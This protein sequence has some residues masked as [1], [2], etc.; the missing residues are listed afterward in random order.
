MLGSDFF[1]GEFRRTGGAQEEK[2]PKKPRK[3]LYRGI[4][5][6]PWGKWAAEI[7]DP[8]KGVRV[9][10]GTYNTAEEAARA[11]DREAR[12]IRGKKAKVNFPN[13]DDAFSTIP[14]HHAHHPQV[15]NYPPLYQANWNDSRAPAKA[16]DL[17][18][19]YDLNQTGQFPPNGFAPIHAVHAEPMVISSEEI[20]GSG[21]EDTHASS[22]VELGAN[23]GAQVKVKEEGGR[24]GE[25]EESE[26]EKLSEELMA[27]ENYMKFYQIPYLDGQSAAA[28]PNPAQESVV[29][30]LW[31]FDDDDEDRNS[32]GV[33]AVTPAAL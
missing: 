12:K 2:A 14:A 33:T 13:E 27:F 19:P 22:T 23:Y 5:Q 28:P 9:W 29:G 7:R 17:A 21:S 16:L 32:A 26:V 8:R 4:R 24:K 10:L 18:F 31:T 20:S 3:N 25:E 6:R 11:Y 30:E 15:H 1:L